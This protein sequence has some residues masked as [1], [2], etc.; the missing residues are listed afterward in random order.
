MQQA[1]RADNFK[2]RFSWPYGWFVAF[3]GNPQVVGGCQLLQESQSIG[4]SDSNRIRHC[5]WKVLHEQLDNC[6]STTSP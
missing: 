4:Q 5:N 3:S 1:D 6:E 2:K